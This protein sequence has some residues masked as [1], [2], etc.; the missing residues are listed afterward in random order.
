MTRLAGLTALILSLGLWACDDAGSS[1][2][3]PMDAA[4]PSPDGMM[5]GD[6]AP[7][8]TDADPPVE[9]DAARPDDAGPPQDAAP[10]VD[11]APVDECEMDNGGCGDPEVWRCIDTPRTPP[12]CVFDETADY[13]AITGGAGNLLSGNALPDSMVL[14]SPTAFV[15]TLDEQDHPFMA[16]AR[17]GSGKRFHVGHESHLRFD[18]PGDTHR[19]L[20]NVVDWMT[21]G[22]TAAVIGIERGLNI[23]VEAI[24]TFGYT[25]LDVAR[26]DFEGLTVYIGT[27]YDAFEEDQILAYETF[28]NEGGGVITGGHAWWWAQS[29]D[30]PAATHF[31]GNAILA[32]AGMVLTGWGDIQSDMDT[33]RMASPGPLHNAVYALAALW[34][35]TA[36]R[37]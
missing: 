31:P 1:A 18:G 25:V 7:P 4:A 24:T 27:T 32:Q 6:A 33:I 26:G 35:T 5:E 16:A 30:S 3:S 14:Y 29:N 13:E 28:M 20:F 34:R 10:P 23:D 9:T 36:A 19:L 21:Q 17:V 15:V 37:A 22:D 12:D 8:D 11:A 2:S